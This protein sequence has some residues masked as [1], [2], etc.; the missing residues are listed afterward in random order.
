LTFDSPFD[1]VLG[2]YVL[3]FQKDPAPMLR[4]VAAHAA[5]GGVIVFH[6]LDCATSCSYPPA[7]IHD[8]VW[9]WW[10]ELLPHTGA[11]PRMGLHLRESFVRAGLGEPALRYEAVA[12]GGAT[13]ADYL[14]NGV[15]PIL[16]DAI[17]DLERLGIAT[18]AEIDY[19]TLADRMIAE[20]IANDSLIIGRAEVGAWVRV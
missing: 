2:R 13:A 16:A 11:D 19:P 6:E 12:F 9:T 4:G 20:V 5:P 1:A 10:I 17:D 3:E 7:P 18:A 14:R 8:R 15:A